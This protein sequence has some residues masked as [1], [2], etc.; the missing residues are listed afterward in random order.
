MSLNKIYVLSDA[1]RA[2][3]TTALKNWAKQTPNVV[4]FLS[5][6]IDGKRMFQDLETEEFI[7]ME[8]DK[9]DL[10]VGKFAF[11]S[12]S[13]E[14]VENKILEA[15]QEAVADF[16]ILDEI[17]PLEINKHLGFHNLLINLQEETSS[18]KPNLFFVVR[19]YCLEIFLEKYGFKN[20]EVMN[21]EEFKSSFS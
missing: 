19:D 7:P 10:L 15:W 6:E 17:G 2:G 11:D 20:I 13:F 4:G 5:P 1:I 12:R 21:L 14:Y 9:K 3:K 18:K 8:T 16:I